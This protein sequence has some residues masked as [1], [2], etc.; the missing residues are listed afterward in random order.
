MKY[1]L[2]TLAAEL[3]RQSG[4]R[5]AV[6]VEGGVRTP[7]VVIPWATDAQGSDELV[8]KIA[9]AWGGKIVAEESH[10]YGRK[11]YEVHVSEDLHFVV[12]TTD[13]CTT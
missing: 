12:S 3:A 11:S 1:Q 9:A 7:L 10:L 5:L 4:H 13:R 2:I 6:L 8:R